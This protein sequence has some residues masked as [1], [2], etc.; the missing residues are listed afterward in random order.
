MTVKTAALHFHRW[1]SR[2]P[3]ASWLYLELL[4]SFL[5]YFRHSHNKQRVLNSLGKI[6]WPELDLR[7]RPTCI[8]QATRITMVPHLLEFDFDVAINK[9]LQYEKE[10][11]A[12]LETALGAYDSVIEIGANVGVF[13]IFCARHVKS[14]FAFEP[15]RMAFERLL[16][17]L[18][19][20][21]VPN[22]QA[23]NCAVAGEY[24]IVRFYE[25]AGHLTNGSLNEGFAKIFSADVKTNLVVTI[26][27]DTLD[28]L[29]TGRKVL[30]KID[31]EGSEGLILTSLAGLIKR[32]QPGIIIEVLSEFES[33]LNRLVPEGYGCYRVTEHGLLRAAKLEATGVRDWVLLPDHQEKPS[34]QNLSS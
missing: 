19:L 6:R 5:R 21:D 32:H 34:S 31:A 14:V 23:F 16:K 9:H 25:P 29:I 26:D 17:N 7:P 8:G 1:V 27:G 4:G 2:S 10:L 11:F 18:T 15:S 24:G 3:A 28:T 22:V 13:T 12:Y 30:I 20:N 33:E